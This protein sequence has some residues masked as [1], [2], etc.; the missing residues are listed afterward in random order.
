MLAAGGYA[1][2]NT[3]VA[4]LA[5]AWGRRPSAV[6]S[7]G[8]RSV[9]KATLEACAIL[10]FFDAIV[11]VEDVAVGKP[12]PGMFLLA[13]E[14]LHTWPEDC[15]VLEDSEQGVEAARR[16]GMDVL[17]VR[18]FAALVAVRRLT[19]DLETTESASP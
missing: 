4:K 13:A 11:T 5:R 7:N 9:V 18:S 2:A 15:L 3:P 14:R 12:D 17:D 10:E 19:S 6:A 16:A 8:E 1:R